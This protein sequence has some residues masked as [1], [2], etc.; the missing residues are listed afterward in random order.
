MIAGKEIKAEAG[1]SQHD[2]CSHSCSKDCPE[3]FPGRIDLIKVKTNPRPGQFD[4]LAALSD[5]VE[6]EG[7]QTE[8]SQKGHRQIHNCPERTEPRDEQEGENN[9][10]FLE[11]NSEDG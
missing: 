7:D 6:D 4:L 11:D 10:A 2:D 9:E 1:D 8:V 5:K 3:W